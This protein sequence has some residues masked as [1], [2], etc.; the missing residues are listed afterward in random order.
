MV[1][2][3]CT[4]V[5]NSQEVDSGKTGPLRITQTLSFQVGSQ[6]PRKLNVCSAFRDTGSGFEKQL[7]MDTQTLVFT[8]LLGGLFL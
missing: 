1:N 2:P 7:T 3:G 4:E 6:F 8:N 5:E